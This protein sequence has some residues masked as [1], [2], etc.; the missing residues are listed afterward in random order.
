MEEE[1]EEEEEDTRGG[2]R[3]SNPVSHEVV[4]RV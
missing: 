2:N 1:E 3:E 4:D